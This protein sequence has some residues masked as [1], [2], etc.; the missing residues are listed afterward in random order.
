MYTETGIFLKKNPS[1]GLGQDNFTFARQP[2][3]RPPEEIVRHAMQKGSNQNAINTPANFHPHN[4]QQSDSF[5]S[6]GDTVN[7]ALVTP[8]NSGS[9]S[10][11]CNTPNSIQSV[12]GPKSSLPDFDSDTSGASSANLVVG[13]AKRK[14]VAPTRFDD[15][16]YLE[17]S[18][19][20]KKSSTEKASSKSS[21]SGSANKPVRVVITGSKSNSIIITNKARAEA[22]RQQQ[23]HQGSA[24]EVDCQ[25]DT[26]QQQPETTAVKQ[27]QQ[28]QQQQ[29]VQSTEQETQIQNGAGS[30]ELRSQLLQFPSQQPQQQ[31]RLQQNQQ[32]QQQQ[33]QPQQQQTQQLQQPQQQQ[34]QQPQQQSKLEVSVPSP[35]VAKSNSTVQTPNST[36]QKSMQVGKSKSSSRPHSETKHKS[37][38]KAGPN[39]QGN[40]GNGSLIPPCSIMCSGMQGTLPSL[41]CSRCLCLFHP[42]CVPEGIHLNQG[43]QFVCPNCIQPNDQGT[44]IAEENGLTTT[45]TT[46]TTTTVATSKT[47]SDVRKSIDGK[48]QVA[49]Q[50]SA[51]PRQQLNHAKS[52]LGKSGNKS[53]HSRHS[54][55]TSVG[56]SRSSLLREPVLT[57][58]QK[59][60]LQLLQHFQQQLGCKPLTSGNYNSK[61][62][63]HSNNMSNKQHFHN[64]QQQQHHQ[65]QQQQHQHHQQQLQQLQSQQQRLLNASKTNHHP[66]SPFQ[67]AP[68]APIAPI[69]VTPNQVASMLDF[70]PRFNRY[71]DYLNK[72]KATLTRLLGLFDFLNDSIKLLSTKDLISFRQVNRTAHAIASTASNWQKVSLRGLTIRDWTYFAEKILDKYSPLEVDFDGIRIP[73]S[74]DKCEFWREF[75]CIVDYMK[76]VCTLKFG[77]VPSSVIGEVI[78]AAVTQNCYN[79]FSDLTT[80]SVKNIFDEDSSTR[81]CNLSILKNV[82][83]LPK[84]TNLIINCRAG[85]KYDHK[86]HNRNSDANANNDNEEDGQNG[87]DDDDTDDIFNLNDT[88]AQFAQLTTLCMVNLKGF[89]SNYF[90][91]LKHLTNLTALEIGSCESWNSPTSSQEQ[92]QNLQQQEKPVYNGQEDVYVTPFEYLE[93]MSHL[94]NLTL[95]ELTLNES[96]SK[97]LAKLVS[98]LPCLTVL[99]LASLTITPDA[100]DSYAELSRALN[101]ANLDNFVIKTDD[102]PTNSRVT[103]LVTKLN[104]VK[105]VSWKVGTIVEDTGACLVPL[106][107]DHVEDEEDLPLE[108]EEESDWTDEK[109]EMGEIDDLTSSLQSFLPST[110][111][112]ITPS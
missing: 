71:A 102:P 100:L 61:V 112:V 55:G 39:H 92:E 24:S 33:P 85:F 72:K 65:Q 79:S 49:N 35:V 57:A 98:K 45:T 62:S 56:K 43:H 94:K 9:S 16:E 78:N 29:P 8:L 97:E 26:Y 58:R 84:L 18:P 48:H 47:K 64:Q 19:F 13:R 73:N 53:D 17:Q 68:I 5:S 50:Q 37:N 69:R 99:T 82:H 76:S 28:Q 4:S 14:R 20:K 25:M 46:T 63:N 103:E 90:S 104:G 23:Q 44:S 51:V 42:Q 89:Q 91:F 34:Q 12:R 3:Y 111:L 109:I 59:S 40:I 21:N 36:Q 87:D 52:I 70:K 86:I 54:N 106:A 93:Q 101:C 74:I 60:Q 11:T 27:Q 80:L 30:E 77:C 67:I 88:F 6:A 1:C 41:L 38:K 107:K 96:S 66:N 95:H 2:I 22:V 105:T 10:P 83:K 32:Q 75:N 108:D 7:K 31:P 110:R 81:E 15:E